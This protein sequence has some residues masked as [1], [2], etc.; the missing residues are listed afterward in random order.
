MGA[1]SWRGDTSI[2]QH[3][4]LLLLVLSPSPAGWG[5]SKTQIVFDVDTM[6]GDEQGCLA[7]KNELVKVG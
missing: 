1:Q 3:C 4:R 7:G 6:R 2:M 5:H